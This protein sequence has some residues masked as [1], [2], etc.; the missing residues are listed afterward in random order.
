MN[1]G[2]PHVFDQYRF[3]MTLTGPIDHLER[4]HLAIVLEHHF[5][6]LASG[7]L[8]IDQ[9]VLAVEPE[10]NAPFLFHSAHRFGVGKQLRTA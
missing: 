10:P 5:G 7:I 6:G 4:D 3:H 9:L 1:W 8:S 2:T